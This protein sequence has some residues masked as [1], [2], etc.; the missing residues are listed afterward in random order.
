MTDNN[1]PDTTPVALDTTPD[2]APEKV[3]VTAFQKPPNGEGEGGRD[4]IGQEHKEA[5]RALEEVTLPED[6]EKELEVA[7]TSSALPSSEISPTTIEDSEMI[8]SA[9]LDFA[10]ML[11]GMPLKGEKHKAM[12]DAMLKGL[13]VEIR[14]SAKL[15]LN[16]KKILRERDG[17]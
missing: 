1:T 12:R 16:A 13:D 15:I 2:T 5:A 8:L 14:E 6:I 17:K 9:Y 4:I 7:A 10:A 11:R 3:E